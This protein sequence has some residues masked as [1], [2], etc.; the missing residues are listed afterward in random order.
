MF[1]DVAVMYMNTFDALKN[2]LQLKVIEKPSTTSYYR[3]TTKY[4]RCGDI[5]EVVYHRHWT[6]F[7][8]L[9]KALVFISDE[10]ALLKPELKSQYEYYSSKFT[11]ER[12]WNLVALIRQNLLDKMHEIK[13]KTGTWRCCHST[14]GRTI[15]SDLIIDDANLLYKHW[16]K[17]DLR[18]EYG[19]IY[20][21]LQINTRY[22]DLKK[23]KH[24]SWLIKSLHNK[25]EV[26]GTKESDALEFHDETNVEGIDLNVK[27]NFC[28]I[29]NGK[30]FDYDRK[31]VEQL[32][33]E[34]KKL[35]KVGLKNINDRD[36]RHLEKLCRR[37][38]WYFKKLISEVLDYCEEQK[39]YDIVLEDLE[40]FNGSYAKNVEFG[41]KYSRLV[42]L[43]R[44]NSVKDWMK[45]QAEKRG[46][47]VHLTLSYYSSQQC[48][49]CGYVD[50][51]NRD[52]QEDFVCCNCGHHANADM[53]AAINL[54]RRYTNVLWKTSLH[55][56]DAYKRLI[57][58]PFVKKDYVKS[59][60][61][62]N[63]TSLYCD[64]S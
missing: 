50:R 39:I 61:S 45:Q 10:N 40:V 64:V 11:K 36:K 5:K 62:K 6:P 53:N 63:E 27:H 43:L 51:E 57:P 24:S 60:L 22:H 44:L 17:V 41:I 47:R 30:T 37:N 58:K 18:K 48:P 54:K 49:I 32:C 1:S 9:L 34:L 52:T 42:R 46:I 14:N 2:S 12:I 25:I 35:D 19:C 23:S 21:P 28:A 20:I 55:D 16:M 56:I 29:S 13:F 26:I 4:H 38:E 33:K 31:Y 15:M 8:R 3:K 59:I 7:T